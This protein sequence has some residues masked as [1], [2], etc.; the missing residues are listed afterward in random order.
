M[1]DPYIHLC[2]DEPDKEED[3][4]DESQKSDTENSVENVGEKNETEKE[5]ESEKEDEEKDEEEKDK[6]EK[7][8]KEAVEG[9][10][11]LQ[12]GK[13]TKQGEAAATDG[14]EQSLV[15]QTDLLDIARE[16]TSGINQQGS[17]ASMTTE[18][19]AEHKGEADEVVYEWQEELNEYDEPDIYPSEKDY[20]WVTE[21]VEV[22]EE[23][24]PPIVMTVTEPEAA[25]PAE[26]AE[27]PK[28]E[29]AP[30]PEAV[31]KEKEDDVGSDMGEAAEQLYAPGPPEPEQ[32]KEPEPPKKKFQAVLVKKLIERPPKIHYEPHQER[33]T[34]ITNEPDS[35]PTPP[36]HLFYSFGYDSQRMANLHVLDELTL[37]YM[38][39]FTLTFFNHTTLDKSYLRCLGGSCFGALGIHPSKQLFAGA[40]KGHNP[41]IGIWSWPKLQLFRKLREGTDKIYASV[42]FSPNGQLLASQGGEPDYLITVW[43]WLAETPLLRVKSH[44]QDVYR[45]TFSKELAGRLTTSGLCHIKFWKMADTFTGLKLKG[46][47]G[48]FGRTE[49]SDIEGYVE[50]PDGK[51]LSGSEWGNLLVWENSLIVAEICIKNDVPCHDGII[52]Q[53]LLNEG[54]F[55]T[56]GQD[57]MVKTWNFD[58]VDTAEINTTEESLKVPIKVLAQVNV[59]EGADIWSI[60]QDI[61]DHIS[62]SVFWFAQDGRGTIWKVDLSFLNTAKEPKVISTAHGGPIVGCCCSSVTCIFAT[63]GA[64]GQVRVYNYIT[65]QL[66]ARAIYSAPGSCLAWPPTM[67][68]LCTTLIAGFADGTFRVIALSGSGADGLPMSLNLEQVR[69]PHSR[70]LA[71]ME[72]DADGEWFVTGGEDGTIFFFDVRQDFLPMAFVDMPDWRA[73]RIVKWA[74]TV[75]E[76]RKTVLVALE[77]G[78]IQEV[79]APVW[80][81]IDNETSY[82]HVSAMLLRRYDFMSIKS[83]LRHNEELQRERIAEEHRQAAMEEEN[84]KRIA[85]GI[86][87]QSQQDLRLLQEAEELER[88]K[89]DE[90]PKKK[91]EP[92]IPAEPSPILLMIS[93]AFESSEMFLSMGKYDAGYMYMIKLQ[94]SDQDSQ[95]APRPH[96]PISA[97]PVP[98]SEDVPITAYTVNVEGDTVFW[99][100]E[101]GRI[102]IQ[103]LMFPFDLEN[104]G[105]HWTE[106]IHDCIRGSITSLALDKDNAFLISCGNDGNCF[107]HSL[108]PQR[109][110]DTHV[111]RTSI[112]S[113]PERPHRTDV[114]D[115]LNAGAYTLEVSK[116]IQKELAALAMAKRNKAAKCE[117]IVRLRLWFYDIVRRNSELPEHARLTDVEFTI[118]KD[119]SERRER[120]LQESLG[121]LRLETAWE[122]ERCS[123]ALNKMKSYYKDVVDCNFFILKAFNSNVTVSSFRLPKFPVFFEQ[124]K[125]KILNQSTP[126]AVESSIMDED[127]SGTSSTIY[128]HEPRPKRKRGMDKFVHQRLVRLWERKQKKI[129]RRHVWKDFLATEPK[130]KELREEDKAIE[131]AARTI[132]DM[133]LKTAPDYKVPDS[134]KLTEHRGRKRL[135]YLEEIVYNLKNVFNNKLLQQ[136]QSKI[137]IIDRMKSYRDI[138][139]ECQKILPQNE[140]MTIPEIESM[141]LEE[142]PKSYMDYAQEDI[143]N[144]KQQME[145]KMKMAATQVA[146]TKSKKMEAPMKRKHHGTQIYRKVSSSLKVIH[147]DRTEDEKPKEEGFDL[148]NFVEHIQCEPSALEKYILR[149]KMETARC[150]QEFY[151]NKMKEE[152]FIFN[153]QLKILRHR[154]IKLD[155]LLKI[156]DQRTVILTQEFMLAQR[157]EAMEAAMEAKILEANRERKEYA[158]Q[159]K[160][161]SKKLELVKKDLD[162][163][164]KQRNA[165][166]QEVMQIAS[167]VPTFE[168][169]LIRVFNKKISKPKVK[170]HGVRASESQESSGSDEDSESSSDMDMDIDEEDDDG[171]DVDFPPP[172]LSKDIYDQVLEVRNGRLLIDDSDTAAKEIY[173]EV[174]GSI[175]AL[176]AKTNAADKEFERG[177]RE[178]E[179]FTKEKQQYLNDIDVAVSL[180]LHQILHIEKD[181]SDALVTENS[182]INRLRHRIPE[183][184]KE[185]RLQRKKVLEVKKQHFQLQREKQKFLER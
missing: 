131:E 70:K 78:T 154:K 110:L 23:E 153:S 158:A 58:A 88:L 169:Y 162:G 115:I 74:K 91:W 130:G 150:K 104:V 11:I 102:R 21:M 125:D 15:P 123:L 32:E 31:V 97:I 108:L 181:L 40:E 145:E 93:S 44:A 4:K 112:L 99:G 113:I 2:T 84:R 35:F 138:I 122:T 178:L 136:R 67:D 24:Q 94:E 48:R 106:G 111:S 69:K 121:N 71:S 143:K 160:V 165:L 60:V 17:I 96:E 18:H 1:V 85:D 147:I 33:L 19:E 39:G 87:T 180:Q 157:S 41:L 82:F 109:D 7:G 36:F 16:L 103:R 163:Y 27:A 182:T 53:V 37:V 134:K 81:E 167:K 79:L 52:R 62:S 140:R 29:E 161:L 114:Q 159:I 76:A 25:A 45:V 185:K 170:E 34:H 49:L 156:A 72:V 183:L 12:E 105:P 47:I 128:E 26:V 179:A 173:D 6:E 28:E 75:P 8:E 166:L 176:K 38:S 64:D 9:E 116:T 177:R 141:T 127:V 149:S 43:S 174:A 135:V 56:T 132:G 20:K 77:G 107:L 184:L 129:Q 164:A 175:N 5:D 118:T 95:L 92:Y 133:K 101:D 80:Q 168:K 10:Q 148:G 137:E 144:Y 126:H 65:R 59:G 54:E 172:E 146:T 51:V 83:V 46:D 63:L 30:A 100:F 66:L 3:K 142:N 14:L 139:S 124:A 117:E 151:I 61:P 73:V 90:K 86:E 68:S 42:N 89:L 98:D 55:Y 50:M 13:E 152:M 57:G 119:S 22:T 171:L 155:Y 120:E